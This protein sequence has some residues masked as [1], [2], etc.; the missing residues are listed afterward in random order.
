MSRSIAARDTEQKRSILGIIVTVPLNLIFD[1]KMDQL[2]K[3]RRR[4]TKQRKREIVV[5]SF[6]PGTSLQT[7]AA[8]HNINP[9]QLSHWRKQF[10]EQLSSASRIDDSARADAGQPD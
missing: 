8:R 6:D 1:R 10:R 3:R 2:A 4:W 5:E 7:V 9:S